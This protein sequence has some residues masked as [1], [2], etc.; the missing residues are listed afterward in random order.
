MK[1][2][3]GINGFGRFG[4]HLLKYWLDRSRDA[5]FAISHI[6]DDVLTIQQA[7]AII[8]SD[9]RVAFDKYKVGMAGDTI[10]FAEPDGTQHAITYTNK[11][12]AEIPWLG[13][14]QVIFECSGKSTSAKDCE[15]Y[16]SGQTRLVIISATSWDA[17]KTLTY[18]FNHEQ[19]AP[20]SRII[21]Y[22]SCTVNAFVPIANY[23]HK[24]Y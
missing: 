18:G 20:E 23:L 11:P 7:F 21:S 6:N 9:R 24:K 19:Y 14:P 13:G 4:L 1:L 16:L 8:S 15:T 5:H 17:D 22:G 12:K 3:T 10:T 2:S